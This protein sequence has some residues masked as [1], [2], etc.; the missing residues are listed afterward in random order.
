MRPVNGRKIRTPSTLKATCALAIW[1]ATESPP[2][3]DVARSASW[4]GDCCERSYA[5][6]DHRTLEKNRCHLV[7][8]P[9]T[10]ECA[11]TV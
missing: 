8:A 7:T 4:D 9:V 11:A 6:P 3:N 5:K 10:F 1:R 2:G